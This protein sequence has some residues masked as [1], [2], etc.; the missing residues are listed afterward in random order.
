MARQ[1]NSTPK[2]DGF[3]MPAEFA[4]HAG[5][6]MLWPQRPDNWRLGAKPAQKAFI[7]VA[8]AIAQFEPLTMGVNHDQFKHCPPNASTAHSCG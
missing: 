6:W 5:T 2:I 1:L 7:A 3:F 4:E 8:T